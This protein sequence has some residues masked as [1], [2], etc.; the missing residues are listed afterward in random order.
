M[1]IALRS[2]ETS[3]FFKIKKE[4]LGISKNALVERCILSSGIQ[5]LFKINFIRC[6]FLIINFYRIKAKGD[7]SSKKG[8][9]H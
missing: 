8:K 6:S 9:G 7:N 1:K 5:K 3:T 2:M 4:L